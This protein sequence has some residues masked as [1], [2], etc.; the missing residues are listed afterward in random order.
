MKVAVY[1]GSFDPITNGHL[2]I[3]SRASKVFDK[4]IVGVLI[5]PDKKGMFPINERVELIKRVIEPFNNV[6]VQ[7]FS[8]L[9]VNFMKKNDSNVM[10]RGLRSVG[11]F[12][13]ELQ[14]SLMNKKL[15]PDVETVFMMTSLEFSF[16][17]STA[18]KQ[19]AVFGG[20]IKGL[21]PDEIINDV[22]KKAKNFN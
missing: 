13:Y 11:D 16:L 3:I 10:I 7:S 4:V 19:V 6:S 1:P 18:I 17:S 12:E 2:D 21:V 20:C 5:N 15:D 8:G 9:L 14:T 22:I